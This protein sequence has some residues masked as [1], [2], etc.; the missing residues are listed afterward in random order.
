M[1]LV[2]LLL[3]IWRCSICTY[4]HTGCETCT[5]N[6]NLLSFVVQHF[7]FLVQDYGSWL[8]IGTRWA[9]RAAP[10][11]KVLINNRLITRLVHA[12]TAPPCFP[13]FTCTL[14][15]TL[16]SLAALVIMWLWCR[17]PSSWCCSVWSRTLSPHKDLQCGGDPRCTFLSQQVFMCTW[18]TRSSKGE[19][20]G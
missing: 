19:K 4:V 9:S 20:M 14:T 8:D 2:R 12:N 5:T 16:L 10:G 3:F 7:F 1:A 15:L 11:L 13:G 6:F 18:G 17:W